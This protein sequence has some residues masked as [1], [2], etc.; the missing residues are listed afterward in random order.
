MSKTTSWSRL[1]RDL[2]G[3]GLGEDDQGASQ[4]RRDQS[5]DGIGDIRTNKSDFCTLTIF[6]S[7]TICVLF[8][9]SH[10]LREA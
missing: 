7:L 4:G 5:L 2:E 3:L 1:G 9:A 10:K 6:F 8:A